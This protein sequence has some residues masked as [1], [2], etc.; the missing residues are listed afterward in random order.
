MWCCTPVISVPGRWRKEG[1]ELKVILIY[2]TFQ[3]CLSPRRPTGGGRKEGRGGRKGTDQKKKRSD[4][5]ISESTVE[6]EVV[7]WLTQ[8]AIIFFKN[9]KQNVCTHS[10]HHMKL[11]SEHSSPFEMILTTRKK[12]KK[13]VEIIWWLQVFI[14]FRSIESVM[15]WNLSGWAFFPPSTLWGTC[16]HHHSSKE[17]LEFIIQLYSCHEASLY[18]I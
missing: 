2:R 18:T 8:A 10:Q 1:Q 11:L 4:N 17:M 16:K 9:C 3:T 12:I 13:Q 6:A 7:S 5:T 15:A 14:L